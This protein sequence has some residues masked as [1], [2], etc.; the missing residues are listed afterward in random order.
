MLNPKKNITLQCWDT[1][2]QEKFQALLPIYIRALVVFD[3]TFRESFVRTQ[4]F[5]RN[6]REFGDDIEILLVE[7]KMI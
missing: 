2:G 3:L 7:I 6:L 5:I 1:A 4:K